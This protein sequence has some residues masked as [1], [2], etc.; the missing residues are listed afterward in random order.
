MASIKYNMWITNKGGL[1]IP[2]LHTVDDMQT[3]HSL[4]TGDTVYAN[5]KAVGVTPSNQILLHIIREGEVKEFITIKPDQD[6][7]LVIENEQS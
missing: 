6:L 2:Y 5:V 7:M 3:I 1:P 4:A